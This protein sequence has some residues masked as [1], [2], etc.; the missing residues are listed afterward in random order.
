ME[1]TDAISINH[2]W[3]NG[4]SV[5]RGNRH[6]LDRWKITHDDML[7]YASASISPFSTSAPSIAVDELEHLQTVHRIFACDTGFTLQQWCLVLL[8]GFESCCNMLT[9]DSDGFFGN[10]LLSIH[11]SCC[12]WLRVLR[13]I[14]IPVRFQDQSHAVSS[15]FDSKDSDDLTTVVRGFDWLRGA[16]H[17]VNEL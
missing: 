16:C 17:S 1:Q 5:I 7:E 11:D 12:E 9:R 15:L 8:N 4:N 2:N 14:E 3:H 10:S 6:L 13:A